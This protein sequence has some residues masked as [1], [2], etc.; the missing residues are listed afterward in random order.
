MIR[1]RSGFAGIPSHVTTSPLDVRLRRHVTHTGSDANLPAVGL[2]DV[3]ALPTD[4]REQFVESD[5]LVHQERGEDTPQAG[6]RKVGHAGCGNEGPVAC[7]YPL[8][9][10]PSSPVAAVRRGE[11]KI[12]VAVRAALL[13]P[14]LKVGAEG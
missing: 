2:P 6:R 3:L 9:P 10:F 7:A 13:A 4:L 12:V 8:L 14:V 1:E 5:A 11:H